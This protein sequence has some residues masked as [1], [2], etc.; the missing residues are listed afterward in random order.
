MYERGLGK[1]SHWYLNIFLLKANHKIMVYTSIKQEQSA[2]PFSILL[3]IVHSS[4]KAISIIDYLN[5]AG[6]ILA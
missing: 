4:T 1:L 5:N 6:F 2:D 3:C